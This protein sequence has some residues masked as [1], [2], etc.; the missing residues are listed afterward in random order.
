MLLISKKGM[1]FEKLR[2]KCVLVNGLARRKKN[3]ELLEEQV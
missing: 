2:E 3:L 1:A